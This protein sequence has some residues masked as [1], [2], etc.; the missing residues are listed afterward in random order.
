MAAH[1]TIR[2]DVGSVLSLDTIRQHVP[3]VFA[4]KPADNVSARYGFVP[5][6]AIVEELQKTGLQVVQA[7]QSISRKPGGKLY[8]RHVLRFR[9]TFAP[10][11]AGGTLPEVVLVNSHNGASGF[12]LW[13]GL[14]R[15]VCANGLI[16]ADSTIGA[17][18]VSHRASAPE[19]ISRQSLEFLGTVDG[20]SE[21]VERFSAVPLQEEQTF[22]LANHAANLRWG[23]SRPAGLN[24]RDLLTAR[25][26]SDAQ[27]NLWHVMNTIQEN[28]I[29]GGV[30][31]LRTGRRSSTRSLSSVREDIRF[32]AGLW[33]AAERLANGEP[34][35]Q[36]VELNTVLE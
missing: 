7:G 21:R 27:R 24:H 9:P 26:Y 15:M 4:D 23:S 2:A 17:I 34:L 10:T 31:L 25:R 16:V 14:F 32:N 33:G 28:V 5:T 20:I 19:V 11:L 29:K 18:S 1:H 36:D 35:V 8:T 6:V 12:K 3:S 22:A 30:Q 13:A